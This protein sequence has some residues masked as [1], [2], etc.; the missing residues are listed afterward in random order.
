MNILKKLNFIVALTCAVLF[1]SMDYD[2]TSFAYGVAIL[3]V[4]IICGI[5]SAKIKEEQK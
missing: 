2:R 5:I 1:L 4:G 3:A